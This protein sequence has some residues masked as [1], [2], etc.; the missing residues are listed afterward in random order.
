MTDM[1]I[2]RTIENPVIVG[3]GQAGALL[4]I[5]LARQGHHVT[6]YE[7]RPDL[8]RV[9]IDAGRSIN[10]ALATRGIVPLIDVGVIERVDAI[11]IPMRGRMVHAVGDPTP[12]LQPY[13]SKPHEV[14]HSVSRSDLNA[15]L[16]D[17]AEATGRVDIVFDATV[18]SV[19]LET[20]TIRFRDGTSAKFGVVFGA[21]GAGSRVRKAMAGVGACDFRTDWLD[22]DY[23]E[24]TL[25][26]AEDGS[27]RIDPQALHI[28]PR[29]E[30]M[31]IA[32]ANPEGDF[33][34][35]LFAPK[36]TFAELDGDPAAVAGFF[37]R[38][39]PEFTAMMPDLVEQFG[40][41]PTGRLGTL[42]ATGWSYQDRAVI[43]GDAAHA[44]VPFHGQGMNAALESVRILDRHLRS[45]PG[46][47]DA[48]FGAY[49]AER[50]PD[51]DAIAA[52]ALGNYL[53]MRSGV[54]D[55]DYLAKRSM[56]LDLEQ[57]HPD[58]LSPRYNMVM[59]STMRYAEAQS[60]AAAQSA[61]ITQA[62]ADRDFD[63]DAAVEALPE[64]P[65]LDPLADNHALS[66][67]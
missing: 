26:P 30:L 6:V 24:L 17:A 58:H 36:T 16:L 48:A 37:A 62:L 7:S 4:A 44:I 23:K 55:P 49:E 2:D 42:H 27:H 40:E 45:T 47:L 41:N 25:A 54:V 51:A 67:S 59:F 1:P 22:H 11:T 53:E 15:I 34:V 29:G 56:A 38:E 8:R 33:T 50:K 28:W 61:L 66:I 18:D 12:D 43:V 46:P 13:G 60:R 5:Y 19:D 35:T 14:I 3:A 65:A 32:L 9:D 52:M 31:L 10:L 64:L 21:D 63:I 20:R 57:R 39:F